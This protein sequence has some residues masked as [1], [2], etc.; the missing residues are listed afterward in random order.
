MNDM[1]PGIVITTSLDGITAQ[2]LAGGFFEHWP[3]HPDEATHLQMLEG[4]MAVSLAIDE[5]SGDVV[6]FATAVGDG[7]LTAHVPLLEV[8]PSHRG[9]GIGSKLVDA[10]VDA[11]SPCYM[12][13]VACDDDVVPFY[14]RFGFTRTNA[15]IR[16]DYSS[17]SGE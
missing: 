4:S 2:Q 9:H 8:L 1:E 10:L 17:Q 5:E 16:R 6:G 3:S 12:I 13:D 15:M 7:V 11:V 14:E